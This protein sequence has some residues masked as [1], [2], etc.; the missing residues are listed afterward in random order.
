MPVMTQCLAESGAFE[1]SPDF[2]FAAYSDMA[3]VKSA[4]QKRIEE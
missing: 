4:L 2:T 3:N 1:E